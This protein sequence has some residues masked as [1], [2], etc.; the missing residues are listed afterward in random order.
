MEALL[1]EADE[2]EPV[3]PGGVLE[4]GP[5][6][7]TV[8]GSRISGVFI[9]RSSLPVTDYPTLHTHLRTLPRLCG[10]AHT[11]IRY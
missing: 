7:V 11:R 9:G 6:Y 4:S 8:E 5:V 3:L 10:Y 2:A 1:I